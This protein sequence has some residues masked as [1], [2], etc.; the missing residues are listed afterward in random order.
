MKYPYSVKVNGI[1]YPANTEIPEKKPVEEKKPKAP[2]A[3]SGE[4]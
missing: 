2:K 4:A 3:K 1:I